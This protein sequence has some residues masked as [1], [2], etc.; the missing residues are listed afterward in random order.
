MDHRKKEQQNGKAIWP[1]TPTISGQM[2]TDK[3]DEE[4]M[5]CSKLDAEGCVAPTELSW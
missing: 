5:F 4:E 3:L 2:K 1:A